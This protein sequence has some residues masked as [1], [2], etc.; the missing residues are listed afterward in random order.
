MPSRIIDRK[1]S[2]PF[3]VQLLNSYILYTDKERNLVGFA[4]F[5]LDLSD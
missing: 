5:R 3:I 1:L 4:I 2:F